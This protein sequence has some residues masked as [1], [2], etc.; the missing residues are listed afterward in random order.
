MPTLRAH[1]VDFEG[2]PALSGHPIALHVADERPAPLRKNQARLE[3]ALHEIVTQLL[4]S[5]HLSTLAEA[6]LRLTLTVR[7]TS[8]ISETQAYAQERCV[9]LVGRLEQGSDWSVDGLAFS[10]HQT[11]NLPSLSPVDEPAVRLKSTSTESPSPTAAFKRS[12]CP[13]DLT[14][15]A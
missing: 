15:Y 4:T 10:C 8:Q 1:Q 11:R 7:D 2:I 3:K 14:T 13:R 12:D 5:Q 6:P 9:A